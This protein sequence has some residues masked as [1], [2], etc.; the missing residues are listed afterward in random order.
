MA[1]SVDLRSR[2]NGCAECGKHVAVC[3]QCLRC[4]HCC[5]QATGCVEWDLDDDEEEDE[6]D[7]D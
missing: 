6:E 5:I 7:D 4:S 3:P 2:A 1:A